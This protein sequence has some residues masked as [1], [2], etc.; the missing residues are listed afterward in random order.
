MNR[1]VSIDEV[2][3]PLD[4]SGIN[5][6]YSI[7]VNRST[8]N[9]TGVN[10]KLSIIDNKGRVN[11]C[12]VNNVIKMN[13]NAG[14]VQNHGIN[15]KVTVESRTQATTQG[16][17]RRE[18]RTENQGQ[19]APRT[20]PV[21]RRVVGPQRGG[22]ITRQNGRQN[23]DQTGRRRETNTP[24]QISNPQRPPVIG[25]TPRR[26]Q[27]TNQVPNRP[28]PNRPQSRNVQN[29]K[30]QLDTAGVGSLISMFL[31]TQNLNFQ[32][33]NHQ[34]NQRSRQ[35]PPR[36]RQPANREQQRAAQRRLHPMDSSEDFEMSYDSSFSSDSSSSEDYSSRYED[37]D[38][39]IE[40]SDEQAEEQSEE[41]RREIPVISV[42]RNTAS[43]QETC[44]VCTEAFNK[45]SQESAF[46]HCNHW[47]HFTCIKKWLDIK[48]KCP[49][50]MSKVDCL[51]V[52]KG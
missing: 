30:N 40:E 35:R 44:V 36:Q 26:N 47:F 51:F 18:T 15:N 50:C 24:Q 29:V 31:D 9:V 27:N 17:Q 48:P 6:V 11:I 23:Q 20:E 16:R 28:R 37:D 25:N 46:L 41:E 42:K 22:G 7:R 10:N 1:D 49:H 43:I 52:N 2:S 33:N 39:Y 13:R 34:Q 21:N 14:Q 32:Y 4:I 45:N 12:G 3:R 19:R 38:L 8:I 5:G